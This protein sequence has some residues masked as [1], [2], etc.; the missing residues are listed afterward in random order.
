M[1]ESHSEVNETHDNETGSMI[2]PPS[3]VSRLANSISPNSFDQWYR[4]REFREN[5]REGTPYFNGTSPITPPERHSPSSLL[6]CHRKTTYNQL[7]APEESEAPTGIFW[8]GS[9]FEEEIVLLFLQEAVVG[10]NEYVTN[11]LWVDF[12]IESEAGELRIK[13]E[14]DPVIVTPDATPLLVTEIKTKDSVGHVETP[15]TH[16]RAQAHAYMKGLSEK[17]NRDVTEAIILYGSRTTFDIKV[18]HIE[19]DPFFWRNT[20]LRWAEQHTTYRLREE[21]PPADPEFSWECEFCSFR[22]R[23]GRG[24]KRYENAG[25]EGLLP[26]YTDYPRENVIEY[27]ESHDGALLPPTLAQEYPKVA[28]QYQV[29]DWQCAACDATF[30]WDEPEWDGNL[31]SLPLCPKCTTTGSPAPLRPPSPDNQHQGEK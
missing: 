19:F 21:L 28:L 31:S 25:A 8:F 26:R 16:H 20:V 13:G 11:S 18:F 10:E 22:E 3:V 1:T 27:L 4:E 24:E 12:T 15:N 6:Q 17:Y 5:I 7:N 23:C 29:A 2:D 14:T 9:Q 30:A